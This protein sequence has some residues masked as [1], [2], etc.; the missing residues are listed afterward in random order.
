MMFVATSCLCGFELVCIETEAKCYLGYMAILCT[1]TYKL[2][3]G[4]SDEVLNMADQ[5]AAIL[6]S[7]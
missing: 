5:G 7:V 3:H 2:S 1:C 4:E 6:V